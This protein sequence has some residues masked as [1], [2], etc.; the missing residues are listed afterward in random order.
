MRERDGRMS[1]RINSA[2]QAD[3]RHCAKSKEISMADFV[4]EA[5]ERHIR[6]LY[7]NYD[8][9]RAEIHRLNQLVAS[10]DNLANRTGSLEKT[11][12]AFFELLL[13]EM[14]KERDS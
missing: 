8:L 3:V 12:Y 5:F 11:S 9:P 13:S 1:I 7:G 6:F 4:E 14:K 2:L 10:M